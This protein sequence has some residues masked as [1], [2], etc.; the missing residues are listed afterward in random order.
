VLDLL[1]VAVKRSYVFKLANEILV[2][3]GGD[4]VSKAWRAKW[5]NHMLLKTFTKTCW[6]FHG[7]KFSISCSWI[8]RSIRLITSVD[9]IE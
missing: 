2:A 3:L 4:Y 9:C 1:L 8:T 7:N 6:P 5:N